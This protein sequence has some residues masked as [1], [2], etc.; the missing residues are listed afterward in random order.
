MLRV[1]GSRLP[2][3]VAMLV[4]EHGASTTVQAA[5]RCWLA[6]YPLPRTPRHGFVPCGEGEYAYEGGTPVGGALER[7][8]G[9]LR[10]GAYRLDVTLSFADGAVVCIPAG[11]AVGPRG[12][13]C[14]HAPLLRELGMLQRAFEPHHG[15]A[16]VRLSAARSACCGVR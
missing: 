13:R 2:L 3:D 1:L 7:W 16:R 6:R 11:V 8:C 5:V 4:L 14:W 12:V 15:A 9:A 10:Q